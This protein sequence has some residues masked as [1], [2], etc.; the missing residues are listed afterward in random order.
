MPPAFELRPA[1][2]AD[3]DFCWPIY[4]DTL[5]PLMAAPTD[6]REPEQRRVVERA[7]ADAG[8]SILRSQGA[9][10]G[11]LHVEE[12]SQVIQLK[13]LL[14]LTALR[15]RGLG[16]SFLNWMKER[17]DRKRKDLTVE[18]MATSPARRLL[19]RLDFKAVPT[20]DGHTVTMRY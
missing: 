18:V 6:W 13:Q 14:V 4:R 10:A 3:L 11:W 1:R 16:T 2:K 20:Q 9:D 8:S 19:E 7:L 17:A 15:N 12:N 5:Q